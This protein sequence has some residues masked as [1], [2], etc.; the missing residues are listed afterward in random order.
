RARR[1]EEELPTVLEF[2]ALCLAAGEGLLDSLRRIGGVGAGELTTELRAAV[3][4]VGTGSS[5][6]TALSTVAQR[7]QVPAVARAVDHVVAAID[8]GAPL[9]QVLQ[10]QASDA[11]IDAKRVLIEQA[12]RK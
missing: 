12:G 4:A 11:R 8:R 3:V 10:A 2:L 7:V 6:S 5:L 1:I 9:A